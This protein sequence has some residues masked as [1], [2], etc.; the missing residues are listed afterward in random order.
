MPGRQRASRLQQSGATA[1]HAT[2][3][4]PFQTSKKTPRPRRSTRRPVPYSQFF[5]SFDGDTE[6]ERADSEAGQSTDLEAEEDARIER[7]M[8]VIRKN[9]ASRGSE[10]GTKY[11]CDV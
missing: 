2:T 5:E 10:G 8:G 6:G 7:S 1:R 3:P 9:A 4:T 11:H